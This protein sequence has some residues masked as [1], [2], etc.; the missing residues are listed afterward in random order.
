[1]INPAVGLVLTRQLSLNRGRSPDEALRDGL[2]GYVSPLAGIVLA[3]TGTT[4]PA[5]AAVPPA[6][7]IPS[8]VAKAV[9]AIISVIREEAS[10]REGEQ[11]EELVEKIERCIEE[12]G[13]GR[14]VAGE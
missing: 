6:E 9:A 7:P 2:V 8:P 4:A 5:P 13:G 11:L 1:M 12:I 3:A 14:A 10:R